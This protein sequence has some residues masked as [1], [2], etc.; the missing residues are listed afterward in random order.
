MKQLR[1]EIVQKAKEYYRLTVKDKPFIPGETFIN[2]GGALCDERE[3]GNLVDEGLVFWLSA[4]KYTEQFER[5]LAEFIGAKKCLA[6]NS[7]SSA[8]LLAFSVLTSW[9]LGDRRIK[10]GDEV[11]T[12]AAGFPTTITPVIQYGA[13]PVFVDI[14]LDTLNIDVSQVVKAITDK[15]KA[16]IVAHTLGIPFNLGAIMKICKDHNLWLI[17]DNCDALGS[18]Y[19]GKYTGSFGDLATQSFY[20]PHHITTGEGGAVLVNN[21]DL[22][23][24]ALSMRNWGRDCTCNPGQDN[25]C[26][27]RHN[28]QHGTLPF[29]YDHKYVCSHF[30][31]NLKF[32]DMQA[33]VGLAQLEKLPEFIL[34]RRYNYLYLLDGLREL[35]LQFVYPEENTKPSW[36]GFTILCPDQKIRDGLVTHLELM[37]IQTRTLFMG[38]ILRQPCFVNQPDTQYRQVGELTNTDTVM[39]ELL[40]IGVYPGIDEPR[41]DWMIKSIKDFFGQ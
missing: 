5:K 7:G 21:I 36:F 35:P 34:K 13:V 4:G 40:W 19:D 18:M 8:N 30:G 31:Y 17:E 1:E 37:N 20:P 25:R 12:V 39:N 11:I 24:I 16:I 27:K 32:T 38:N 29:G 41:L 2:F 22:Y 9:K 33:A 3:F 10:K 28:Q 26:G 14:K 15:T 6:V 23:D